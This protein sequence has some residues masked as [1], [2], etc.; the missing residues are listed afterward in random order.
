MTHLAVGHLTME[1]VMG[2]SIRIERD[3]LV[4]TAF[5]RGE[6][7]ELEAFI[8]LLAEASFKPREKRIGDIVI[9]L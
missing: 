2:G 7:T 1:A 9:A 5:K 6:F 8:W 3:L 4:D